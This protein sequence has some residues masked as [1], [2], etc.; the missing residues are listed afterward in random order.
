MGRIHG[1]Y[2]RFADADSISNLQKHSLGHLQLGGSTM[3]MA[4]KFRRPIVQR[5]KHIP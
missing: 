5:K 4:H 3:G 1:I 2:H